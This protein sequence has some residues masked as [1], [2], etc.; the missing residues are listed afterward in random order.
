MKPRIRSLPIVRIRSLP[1]ALLGTA[2]AM[3]LLPGAS[4]A[5]GGER[6]NDAHMRSRAG[7]PSTPR[8]ASPIQGSSRYE[9][10]G[11]LVQ[12]VP[13]G[14]VEQ[15]L[16]NTSQH[17]WSR[18]VL[19]FAPEAPPEVHRSPRA[20]RHHGTPGGRSSAAPQGSQLG[21]TRRASGGR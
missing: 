16:P 18:R 8:V 6:W 10:I 21:A 7:G 13:T 14:V 4:L 9:Q 3:T 2:I 15:I 20:T 1:F 19:S 12:P 11:S 5:A 17:A